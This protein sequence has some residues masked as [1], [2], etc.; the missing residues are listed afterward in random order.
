LEKIF[1]QRAVAERVETARATDKN[2][3]P[4]IRANGAL[5]RVGQSIFLR[6]SMGR[7]HRERG[8]R[9]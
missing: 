4:P 7:G 2:V 8:K 3:L 6:R 1:E 5:P 9:N